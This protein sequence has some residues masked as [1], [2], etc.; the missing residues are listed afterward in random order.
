M[1][2]IGVSVN[3]QFFLGWKEVEVA[4]SL[5]TLCSSFSLSYIDAWNFEKLLGPYKDPKS[6]LQKWYLQPGDSAEVYIDNELVVTGYIDEVQSSVSAEDRIFRVSG[7]DVTGDLVDCAASKDKV[8]EFKNLNIQQIAALVCAP[9]GTTIKLESPVGAKFKRVSVDY[10]QSVFD[11]LDSLCKQRGVLLTTNEA[12][13]LVITKAGALRSTVSLQEGVNVKAASLTTDYKRR[14]RDYVTIG[15]ASGD[16]LFFG[17]STRKIRG[18]A[19]DEDIKRYRPRV[20][21]AERDV[22]RADAI[23]RSQWEAKYNAAK[24]TMLAVTVNGWRQGVDKTSPLWK[25][26][27]I[28]E[29]TI[30]SLSIDGELLIDSVTLKVDETGGEMTEL[31]LT[32][33]DAWVPNPIVKSEKSAFLDVGRLVQ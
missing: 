3:G 13:A 31:R 32:R 21:I 19:T 23:L 33:P 17:E 14:F 1:R 26:N 18:T 24:G 16:A 20:V 8:R 6:G 29:V 15:Q 5:D 27:S 10:G 12:G 2:E 9:F 25:I 11:L 30:P 7:R 4:R 22:S 28:T